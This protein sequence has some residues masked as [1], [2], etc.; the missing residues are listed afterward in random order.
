MAPIKNVSLKALEEAEE[1]HHHD[2]GGGIA[3]TF[4]S[5]LK[6]KHFDTNG[7]HEFR[8][9]ILGETLISSM[10]YF[11]PFTVEFALIGASVAHIMSNH[12]GKKPQHDLDQIR[13]PDPVNFIRKNRLG[14]IWKG[15]GAG[16]VVLALAVANLI[17]FFGFYVDD[18]DKVSGE[19]TSK[20]IATL[21]NVVGVVG[22]VAGLLQTRKLKFKETGSRLNTI[23][24]DMDMTLLQVRI[25][26]IDRFN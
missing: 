7:C 3:R 1:E 11:Y 23:E 19:L 13:E 21:A 16:L 14:N 15:A 22:L 26:V 24:M 8:S 25:L 18:E 6:L 17:L 4:L 20:I 5:E 2:E 12:I 10:P 9:R